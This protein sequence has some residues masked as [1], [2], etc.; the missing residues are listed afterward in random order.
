MN[1]SVV[2]VDDH[3]LLSQAIGGLV[4]EFKDF[5]VLYLC[6]NGQE[7]LDKFETPKNVPDLVLMDIKM[8]ILNGI[9]TTELLRIN[10]PKV[11]VLALSIEE[12]EYTILKM[13]RAGAKGYLMKDTKKDILEEA[14]LQV[15]ET[16]HYYT[17]T[18]SQIL[19]E[20]LEKEIDTELKEKEIEFIKLA[21]TDMNYKQISE[22]M[23][24]SYKTVEG[25][26]DAL[27]KKLGIKNRIGLVLF[28]IHH[29]M[30]TP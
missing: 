26:R 28:A 27:Y 16:G 15:M 29:N 10:Y 4:Q 18:V 20:S 30:F 23:F 5:E 22:A 12:D 11:K 7:L 6:K 1:H 13:L 9:E 25:Y 19:M 21:C 24:C 8:P 17:N 2:V 14:L 3:F